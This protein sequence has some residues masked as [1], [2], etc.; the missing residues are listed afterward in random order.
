MANQGRQKMMPF[1]AASA[2]LALV[3]LA[4]PAFAVEAPQLPASAKKLSGTEILTLYG[5]STV[6]FNNFTKDKPLSGTVTYDLKKKMHSGTYNLG[7]QRGQFSGV[8]RVNGDQFC[9]KEG[10]GN[11][12]CVFVYTDGPDIYEV[13]AKGVIESKNQKR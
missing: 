7:G 8:N 10:S 6:T 2:A 11:E 3:L 5:G 9:H 13:N 12:D 1:N 4:K